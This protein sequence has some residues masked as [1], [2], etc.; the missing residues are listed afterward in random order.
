MIEAFTESLGWVPIY[1]KCEPV[2]GQKNSLDAELE[3]CVVTSQDRRERALIKN[4]N[5]CCGGVSPLQLQFSVGCFVVLGGPLP[6]SPTP[7]CDTTVACGSGVRGFVVSG[8]WWNEGLVIRVSNDID[9]DQQAQ[10][11]R[12]VESASRCWNVT[13]RPCKQ[14]ME[15]CLGQFGA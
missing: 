12:A 8:C 7:S 4:T 11:V 3:G 9:R 13:F 10:K 15:F 6:S 2:T 1:K 14:W 5:L